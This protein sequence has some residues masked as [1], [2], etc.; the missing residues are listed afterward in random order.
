MIFCWNSFVCRTWKFHRIWFVFVFVLFCFFV[1]FVVVGMI[2]SQI[3]F[4]SI[5]V[6]T[7]DQENDLK[8]YIVK[9]MNHY[10]GLSPNELRELAYPPV[11]SKCQKQK[12]SLWMHTA[13]PDNSWIDTSVM[14]IFVFYLQLVEAKKN[15][16]LKIIW[17]M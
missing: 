8:E 2:S 5:Q 13:P 16:R 17:V 11:D 1:C 12:K 10:Y 6:F 3:F 4:F 7:F 14:I 9:C 15:K